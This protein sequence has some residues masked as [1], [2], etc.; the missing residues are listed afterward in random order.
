MSMVDQYPMENRK[1]YRNDGTIVIYQGNV[2]H[3]YKKIYLFRLIS[4]NAQSNCWTNLQ[5]EISCQ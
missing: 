5:K 1:W 4:Y 3:L 2:S